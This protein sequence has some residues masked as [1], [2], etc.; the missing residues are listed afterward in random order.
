MDDKTN[1]VNMPGTPVAQTPNTQPSTSRRDW[2][3][4]SAGV[5][6]P[7]TSKNWT[8]TTIIMTALTVSLII[9]GIVLFSDFFHMVSGKQNPG[10]EFIILAPMFFLLPVILAALLIPLLTIDLILALRYLRE[11]KPE[12]HKR[13]LPY[14]AIVA[15]IAAPVAFA[16]YIL[17]T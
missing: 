11:N 13:V 2:T 10:L 1:I 6:H 9:L 3:P 7:K 4:Q 16:Y 17:L 5:E 12:L 15:A 8:R 14:L